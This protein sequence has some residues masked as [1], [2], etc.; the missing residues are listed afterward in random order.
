MKQVIED[1]C[2][3]YL[4][5]QLCKKIFKFDNLLI[6]FLCSYIHNKFSMFKGKCPIFLKVKK[7]T[8]FVLFLNPILYII[9]ILLVGFSISELGSKIL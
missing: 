1:M 7:T 5:L 2:I 9:M 4:G 6:N 8:V 3:V